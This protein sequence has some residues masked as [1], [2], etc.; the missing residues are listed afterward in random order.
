MNTMSSTVNSFRLLCPCAAALER[1]D[2]HDLSQ[3]PEQDF[4]ARTNGFLTP[5]GTVLT[6]IPVQTD[7]RVNWRHRFRTT[8]NLIGRAGD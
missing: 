2:D 1:G 5:A 3:R 8:A 6:L 4:R 7:V